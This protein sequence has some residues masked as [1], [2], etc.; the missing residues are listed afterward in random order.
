MLGRRAADVQELLEGLEEVPLDSIYFHTH[1]YFLRHPYIAGP[2]P[3]DFA[4]WAAIQLRDRVLGERLAV[5]DPFEVAD[6]EALRNEVVTILD[7]HLSHVGSVPRVVF[8]ELFYFMQSRILAVPAG[9]KARTLFEFRDALERIDA[10]AVYY[11]VF[12]AM[13]RKGKRRSDFTIWIED[14]LG[15][16]ELAS[17]FTALNPYA[18]SLEGLRGRLVKLCEAAEREKS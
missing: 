13:A 17:R 6:L 5:I 14:S 12:D 3:N 7:D 2:Y 10:S 16:R 9:V 4:N 8:G 1:S 15:M 18:S 11:H